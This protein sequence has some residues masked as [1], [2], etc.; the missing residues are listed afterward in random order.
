MSWVMI[1]VRLHTF[2]GNVPRSSIMSLRHCCEVKMLCT[3]SAT[4]FADGIACATHCSTVPKQARKLSTGTQIQETSHALTLY[5]YTA[6]GFTC[7][8][9]LTTIG[10]ALQGYISKSACGHH[11]A[12]PHLS[13]D[14]QRCCWSASGTYACSETSCFSANN[15]FREVFCM[16][17]RSFVSIE[18][19]N[20]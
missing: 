9:Q 18:G 8:Q 17:R 14:G 7:H 6:A 5:H 2:G 16:D 12:C 19:S 1:V 20:P 4:C 15:P 10:M 3:G 11:S 13:L